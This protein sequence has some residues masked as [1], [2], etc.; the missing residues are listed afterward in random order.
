MRSKGTAS[1]GEDLPSL[2]KANPVLAAVCSDL[3]LSHKMPLARADADWYGVQ[4]DYLQQ[5]DRLARSHSC[6]VIIAGDIFDRPSSPSELVNLALTYLPDCYA[7]PGQH[8]MVNHSWADIRK[9]S[10]YTLVK[11]RKIVMLQ[12]GQPIEV[13]AGTPM[14]VWGFPWGFPIK[15]PER[16][17]DMHLN[18]AMCHAYL[19]TKT[20]GYLGAPK[21]SRLANV[22]GRLKGFDVAIIGDNHQ[23]FHAKSGDCTVWNNGTLI[24]RKADEI[25]YKPC[26]GLLHADG[27]IT[28]HYLDTSRDK[29]LD[30]DTLPSKVNTID[31]E[32]FLDELTNLSDSAAN[33][34]H[35]VERLLEQERMPQDVKRL[36][37]KIL[38]RKG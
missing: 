26:V 2:R 20:T 34:T 23:H 7:V 31:F 22:G 32:H 28:R 21:E 24:R 5:I 29:F 3:H 27:T 18:V 13:G 19:W 17:Y 14:M 36:I 12:P 10:F 4:Q 16:R 30:R 8:D 9:S 33:F 37:L 6:A 1:Q 11:A 15:P 38:D 25:P 35:E